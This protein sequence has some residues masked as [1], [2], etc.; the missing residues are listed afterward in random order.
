MSTRASTVYKYA[1]EH[2]RISKE[3]RFTH[4]HQAENVWIKSLDLKDNIY[5]P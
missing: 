3:R 5:I 4:E 2:Y 1:K